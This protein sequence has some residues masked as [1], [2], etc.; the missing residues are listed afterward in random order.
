MN[1]A[2]TNAL[3]DTTKKGAAKS[4]SRMEGHGSFNGILI[5]QIMRPGVTPSYTSQT[6]QKGYYKDREHVGVL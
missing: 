1:Q 2:R 3:P 4:V 5:D 6:Q